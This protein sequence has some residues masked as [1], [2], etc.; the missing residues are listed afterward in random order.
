MTPSAV[1]V[2]QEWREQY[3]EIYNLNLIS[4]DMVCDPLPLFIN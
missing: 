2:F 1:D 3:G 4:E